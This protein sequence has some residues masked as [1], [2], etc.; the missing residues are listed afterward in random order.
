M[1]NVSGT[2]K[3]SVM[4]ECSVPG[5]SREG[6]YGEGWRE[7]PHQP[8]TAYRLGIEM[9]LTVKDIALVLVLCEAHADELMKLA[10]TPVDARLAEWGWPPRH[11]RSA[12][13]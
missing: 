2:A 13:L 12:A 3:I 11:E 5:C 10:W 1:Q 4:T 8:L 6:T 9:R 7:P